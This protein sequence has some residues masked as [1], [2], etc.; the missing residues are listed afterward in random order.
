MRLIAFL[1]A[2]LVANMAFADGDAE[3]KYRQAV[4][5]A[6]GGHMASM[7]AILRGRTHLGDL[8]VHA[9][10]M[11]ELAQIVPTVFPEGSGDGKTEALPAIWEKA[12]DFKKH[13]D[14]YVK[15]ANDMADAANSGEMGRIGPAIQAL[16]Q[17]CKGCH[18]NFRE[19]HDH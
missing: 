6:V 15:A 10:A 2:M 11:A 7:G 5:K 1:S 16:G 18:D 12:D 4:M 13:V 14:E 19:E 9:N 8:D 17:S 3:I